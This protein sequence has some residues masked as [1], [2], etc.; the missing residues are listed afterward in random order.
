MDQETKILVFFGGYSTGKTHNSENEYYNDLFVFDCLH[1]KWLQLNTGKEQVP[2]G[3]TDHCLVEHQNFL[4]IFAGKGKSK[5]L[6]GDFWRF[7]LEN[8]KWLQI[9]AEGAQLRP[10]FGHSA[11]VY[12]DSM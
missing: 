4:Y 6:L 10:R 8:K 1:S 2:E 5:S 11:V 12:G 9:Q 3:R 7:N